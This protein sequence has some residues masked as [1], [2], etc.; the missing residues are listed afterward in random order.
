ME[1]LRAKLLAAVALDD[2]ICT[3]TQYTEVRDL[4]FLPDL[5]FRMV[6]TDPVKGGP[7]YCGDSAYLVELFCEFFLIYVIIHDGRSQGA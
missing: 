3:R 5:Q 6:S 2:D 1:Q 4:V 7:A